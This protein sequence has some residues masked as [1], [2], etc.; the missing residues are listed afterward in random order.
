LR[1]Q[2]ADEIVLLENER[3]PVPN[4]RALLFGGAVHHHD[5]EALQ[6]TARKLKEPF[7]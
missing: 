4:E 5:A 6:E 2:I 7:E 1:D 3:K